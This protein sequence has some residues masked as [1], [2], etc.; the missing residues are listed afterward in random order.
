MFSSTVRSSL[1]ALAL[2]A[3]PL[4]LSALGAV[5]AQAQAFWEH[6]DWVVMTETNEDGRLICHMFTGGDGSDS[7][8]VRFD[9]GD[10]GPPHSHPSIRY[11]EVTMRGI[12]PALEDGQ[13]V[14][15]R[16]DTGQRFE[17]VAQV[18]IRE[19]GIP[20]AIVEPSWEDFQQVLQAMRASGSL[21]VHDGSRRLARF[22]MSGFTAGYL[23]MSDWCEFDAST[24]VG[25]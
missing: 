16:L 23:K 11:E 14:T 15:F 24:V 9:T 22:S 10:A 3:A 18:G 7:L 1:A 5:P 25:K 4:A 13:G 20:F 2:M 19:D 21:S 6:K 8:D 12:K 17:A